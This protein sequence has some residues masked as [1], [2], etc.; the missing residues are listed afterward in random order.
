MSPET[1]PRGLFRCPRCRQKT[2][3]AWTKL[4]T[5]G[6]CPGCGGRFVASSWG[7]IPAVLVMP[8]AVLAPLV[9]LFQFHPFG[10]PLFWLVFA[11][12]TVLAAALSAVIFLFTTLLYRKGSVAS[13]WDAIGFFTV[14]AALIVAGMTNADF[15]REAGLASG[16]FMLF[17]FG[18][19]TARDDD[20]L[21]TS[22][23][24]YSDAERQQAF[25][26]ALGKAGIRYKLE[27]REGKEFVGWTRAQDP[28]VRK[29]QEQ[30]Q[31]RE[32]PLGRSASFDDLAIKKEF[33]AWLT[34]KGLKHETKKA[35][36]RD[37][38]VWEGPDNLVH[39]FMRER[40]FVP[41]DKKA[42]ADGAG[43]KK[44]G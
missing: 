9:L 29:I 39:Q 42:A 6:A 8:F 3:T 33:A 22:T 32:L 37:Y 25:K 1:A 26:D 13:R 19:S 18:A 34:G 17:P 35:H 40:P 12:G 10:F 41:C 38:I 23:V 43:T 5:R 24:N 14:I 36:G 15:D 44:C 4:R 11:A 28:A 7:S 30:V 2:I 20:K 31:G 21:I 27:T 16:E